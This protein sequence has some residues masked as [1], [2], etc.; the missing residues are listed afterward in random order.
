MELSWKHQRCIVCLRDDVAMT[1]SHLV[2]ESLGGFAWSR[3]LCAEC[4]NG[5]GARVE[6]GVKHDPTIRYAIEDA[7]AS[8]LPDLARGF[9]EGQPYFVPSD[10]GPLAARYREGAIELGTTQLNDGS[11]IQDRDRAAQTIETV[12]ERTG[13]DAAE[14]KAALERIA[15]A[16]VGELVDVGSG[17]V[18]R[19]GTTEGASMTFDGQRVTDLFPLAIAYH[20]LAFFVGELIYV[21]ALE[22]IRAMLRG[23]QELDNSEVLVE[24]LIDRSTGYVPRHVVG[25][26]RVEPHLRIR[27]QLFGPPLWH[28]HLLRVKAPK[29]KPMGMA[30]DLKERAV[31]PAAPASPAVS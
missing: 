30:L 24:S 27:V 12:L 16:E 11:L 26:S 18:I 9:A 2:P 5:L 13:A 7:L 1:R 20:L 14:R 8:E 4:N 25:L 17:L 15:A 10:Q 19:H 29:L 31:Y 3:T 21:D 6:S 23:E 28:V 22:P